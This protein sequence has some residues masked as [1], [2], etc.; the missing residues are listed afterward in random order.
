M[1]C[2]PSKKWFGVNASNSLESALTGVVGF[3]FRACSTK[4]SVVPNTSSVTRLLPII[5]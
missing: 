1:A 3:E 5:S 4:Q 2:C